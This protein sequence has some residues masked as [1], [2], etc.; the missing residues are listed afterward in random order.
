[1][2][3][4]NKDR[5]GNFEAKQG[6]NTEFGSSNDFR[7]MDETVSKEEWARIC[8]SAS[9]QMEEQTKGYI[10]FGP[11]E[12]VL[13]GRFDITDL[14]AILAL[15]KTLKMLDMGVPKTVVMELG[16]VNIGLDFS[17]ED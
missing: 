5:N 4:N 10:S 14:E 17:K 3:G 16:V 13:D 9:E 7:T 2:D 12:V 11:D 1:M 8:E 15:Q 6:R